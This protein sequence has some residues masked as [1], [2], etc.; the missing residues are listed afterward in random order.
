MLLHLQKAIFVYVTSPAFIEPA[1]IANRY[2]NTE[3]GPRIGPNGNYHPASAGE[4]GAFGTCLS[5]ANRVTLSPVH[6]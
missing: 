5:K 2:N 1:I 4:V 3:G 6:F